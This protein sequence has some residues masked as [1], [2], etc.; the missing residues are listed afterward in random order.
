[1]LLGIGL[2]SSI[3]CTWVGAQEVPEARQAAPERSTPPKRTQQRQQVG[4]GASAVEVNPAQPYRPLPGNGTQSRETI[5]EFYLRALN[6]R[7]VKWGDEID[8]RFAVLA[9]QSVGNPY[10]RV[11]AFQTGVILFVLLL[12]WVWWDKMRQIKWIADERLTDAVNA[13]TIADQ[14]AM[15]AIAAHNQ[16]IESCNRAIER[17]ES[18]IA[19][20]RSGADWQR[21][22]KDL[23]TQLAHERSQVAQLDAEVTRRR[24]LQTQMEGRITQLEAILQERKDGTNAELLARLQRAESELAG[25]K[26]PRK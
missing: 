1:M 17:H 26:S 10:F 8:R 22:I 19:A 5:F 4:S 25:R 14:R 23:Q 18:G 6:P 7:H 9:E 3:D 15:E 21:E 2:L 13:K 12:C 20:G 11:C 24:D 16:H